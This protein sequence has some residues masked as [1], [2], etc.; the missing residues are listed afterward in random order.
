MNKKA[1]SSGALKPPMALE[2]LD[3]YTS[4]QLRMHFLS[5]GLA[6]K[7]VSFMPQAFMKDEDKEG[8]DTVLKDGNLL[9]N[10]LN[11][12]IRSC[13]YTSQKHFDSKIPDGIVSESVNSDIQRAVLDYEKHMASHDF[14][15][16]TYDLDSVI[17]NMSKYW[18]NNMKKAESDSDMTLIKQI[19]LDSF[20]AV[21]VITTLLHPITPESS[22][23]VRNYLNFNKKM[24]DWK[25]IFSNLEEFIDNT[26]THKLK[27]LEPK[28][29]F[30]TKHESQ[31]I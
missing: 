30:F 14:H 27:F 12:L 5:L 31:F 28:V 20:F 25:Y 24:W 11:R 6:K 2:L 9:S 4:D 22:E 18:A 3:F 19:L 17:R 10:V 26:Q 15:L 1:S 8:P 23:N 21:R 16:V 7:S 29:D 13:F